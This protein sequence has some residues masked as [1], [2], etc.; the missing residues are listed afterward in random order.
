L[1]LSSF[2]LPSFTV[3]QKLGQPVPELNLVLEV[4]RL[5]AA[6]DTLVDALIFAVVILA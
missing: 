4:N 5:I 6:T 3:V 1:S 2:T